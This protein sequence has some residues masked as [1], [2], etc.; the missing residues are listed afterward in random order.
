MIVR[1]HAAVTRWSLATELN[2]RCIASVRAQDKADARRRR[3]TP[4]GA[5]RVRLRSCGDEYAQCSENQQS[6]VTSI[7][8]EAAALT[9]TA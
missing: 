4:N 6:G 1:Q 9:A 8:T 3:S 2:I 5:G 7:A